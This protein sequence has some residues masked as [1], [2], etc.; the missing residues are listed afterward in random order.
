[1]IE[2]IPCLPEGVK[3]DGEDLKM[4]CRKRSFFLKNE[5]FYPGF[6]QDTGWDTPCPL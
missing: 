5:E 4:D 6:Y 2:L 1:M 3:S